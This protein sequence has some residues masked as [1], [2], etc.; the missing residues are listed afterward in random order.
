MYFFCFKKRSFFLFQFELHKDLFCEVNYYQ[1][2]YLYILEVLQSNPIH[3]VVLSLLTLR[4][5]CCCYSLSSCS[6]IQSSTSYSNCNKL[7]RSFV[8]ERED[9]IV[10]VV[11]VV[12]VVVLRLLL[13]PLPL[14]P[15]LRRR[16]YYY[17]YY[18]SRPSPLFARRHRYRYRYRYRYRHRYCCSTSPFLF[19]NRWRYV[20]HIR[21]VYHVKICIR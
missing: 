9:V 20:Y 1:I 17:N 3:I 5:Y 15:L 18:Y 6:V 13:L 19:T 10:V 8:I 7:L 16:Y 11:I 21:H 4:C 14:L 12:V 2:L